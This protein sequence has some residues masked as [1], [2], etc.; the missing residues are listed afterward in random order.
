MGQEADIVPG[1]EPPVMTLA[2]EPGPDD[3]PVLIQL[4]YKIDP[5]HRHARPALS[6]NCNKCDAVAGNVVIGNSRMYTR[7]AAICHSP[8]THPRF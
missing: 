3:G 4:E 5:E 2:S 1:V 8:A 7:G 6:R